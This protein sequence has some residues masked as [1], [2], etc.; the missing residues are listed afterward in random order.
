MA[1]GLNQE[2]A[3]DQYHE[4]EQ[5]LIR[6]RIELDSLDRQQGDASH[7]NRSKES[8]GDLREYAMDGQDGVKRILDRLEQI[9]QKHCPTQNKAQVGIQRFTDVRVDRSRRRVDMS[10]STKA[11]GSDRHRN[12]R[13]QKGGYGVTVGEHLRLTEEG[14]RGNWRCENNSVVNEVP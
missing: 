3:S 4:S 12:H 13:Q 7:R 6:K 5:H 8:K 10:H 14:N 1:E 2:Y 11:D 9:L